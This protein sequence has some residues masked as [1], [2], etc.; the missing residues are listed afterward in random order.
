MNAQTQQTVTLIGASRG[1]GRAFAERF[2]AAGAKVLVVARG[3]DDLDTLSRDLPG[4]QIL[5]IDAAED[6]AIDQVLTVQTPDLL[7]QCGGSL[8][9]NRSIQ[10][11]DWQAFSNTWNTDTRITFN[12]VQAVLKTPLPAGTT[13]VTVTSGAIL[14]GS[15]ISGGY[16]GAKKMQQFLSTYAQK[17]SD[18]AGL[19]QRYLTLAPLRLL[20]GTGVGAG[21][22]AGYAKYNGTSEAEFLAATGPI[23]TPQIATDAL[24]QIV[25]EAAPGAHFGVGADGLSALN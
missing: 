14:N 9:P 11:I 22:I 23:L 6:T 21:G 3:Q 13:I 20:P 24:V 19:G 4:I 8:A 16:A 1:I 25:A 18:R 15:P 12:I 17:E 2:H 10:D 5:A 7:I